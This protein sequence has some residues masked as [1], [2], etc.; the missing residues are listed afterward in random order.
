MT[1]APYVRH[2][3]HPKFT[4]AHAPN[5][6]SIARQQ[7]WPLQIAS[8]CQPADANGRQPAPK[9]QSRLPAQSRQHQGLSRQRQHS[10]SMAACI[11]VSQSCTRPG[12]PTYIHKRCR[13]APS[14]HAAAPLQQH[15]N[16][17]ANASCAVQGQHKCGKLS[18]GAARQCTVT[19]PLRPRLPASES[20]IQPQSLCASESPRVTAMLSVVAPNA[21]PRTEA[22]A[23]AQHCR[24]P[25]GGNQGTGDMALHPVH[26]AQSNDHGLL[27]PVSKCGMQRWCRTC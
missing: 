12:R 9:H 24:L 5:V 17:P 2:Q 22:A 20:L 15:N 26:T 7:P 19:A 27:A 13:Q 25:Q 10:T 11:K 3:M 1:Q 14:G 4:E 6:N 8:S 21:S 23:T 18:P 16:C